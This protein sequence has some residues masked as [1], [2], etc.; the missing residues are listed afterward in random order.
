MVYTYTTLLT[1]TM[2]EKTPTSK[3]DGT[4]IYYIAQRSILNIFQWTIM[5]EKAKRINK[6]IYIYMNNFILETNN[7]INQLNFNKN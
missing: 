6:Y 7:I 4:R 3:V 5:V 1:Y 2:E